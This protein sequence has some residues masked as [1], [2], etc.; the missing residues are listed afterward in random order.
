MC[1]DDTCGIWDLR[2][3][4]LDDLHDLR[5]SVLDIDIWE[6]VEIGLPSDWYARESDKEACIRAP[7]WVMGGH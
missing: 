1:I 3:G 6:D 4:A 2:V 7:R 5:E